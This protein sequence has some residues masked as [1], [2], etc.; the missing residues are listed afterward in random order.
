MNPDNHQGDSNLPHLRGEPALPQP[1][2]G[3]RLSA[4]V[5]RALDA[6]LATATGTLGGILVDS[7]YSVRISLLNA[8]YRLLGPLFDTLDDFPNAQLVL[9][10][11]I[12]RIPVVLIAG[13]LT[14]LILR[15]YRYPWLVLA[16]T[17]VW[18]VYRV[19]RKLAMALLPDR[20]DGEHA[21]GLFQL[22]PELAL[23]TLQYGLLLI[24]IV[25]TDAVLA[26]CA[27]R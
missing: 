14:G 3:A 26:R 8:A 12:Q 10:G 11:F 6:L 20:S 27:A 9:A 1:A 25:T 2:A 18:M 16:S 23:Y 5:R 24:V 22:A 13:L 21:L 7:G 4:D 15:W 19:G 17:L